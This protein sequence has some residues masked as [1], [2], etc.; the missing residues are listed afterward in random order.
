ML[1]ALFNAVKAVFAV[2]LRIETEDCRAETVVESKQKIYHLVCRAETVL[3]RRSGNHNTV[4]IKVKLDNGTLHD[5]YSHGK[6]RELE[7]ER[8][9]VFDMR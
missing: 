3:G 6:Y 7:S 9:S 2:V 4:F 8:Q 1:Q 5:E